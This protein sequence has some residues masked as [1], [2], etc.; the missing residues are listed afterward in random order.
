[1]GQLIQAALDGPAVAAEN[2]GDVGDAAMAEFDGLGRG[3]EAAL[4]LVEVGE[5]VAHSPLHALGILGDHRV[6]P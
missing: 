2:Q 4:T 6:S 1:V 5:S 3:E